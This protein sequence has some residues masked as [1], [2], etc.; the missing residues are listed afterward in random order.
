[1]T[2]LFKELLP[3]EEQS[4]QSSLFSILSTSTAGI[5]LG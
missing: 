2:E 3:R 5:T 1:M 4:N